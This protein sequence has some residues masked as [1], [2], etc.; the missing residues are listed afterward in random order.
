MPLL[1]GWFVAGLLLSGFSSIWVLQHGF[2][3]DIGI[4]RWRTAL[5]AVSDATAFRELFAITFPP[6]PLSADLI[7]GLLPGTVIRRGKVTRIS[8]L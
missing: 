4:D 3:A 7:T 8:G 2:M 6:L 5:V 1:L